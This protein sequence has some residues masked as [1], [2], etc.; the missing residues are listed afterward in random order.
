M[1]ERLNC[2]NCSTHMPMYFVWPSP[3]KDSA[4]EAVIGRIQ[5]CRSCGWQGDAVTKTRY[6]IHREGNILYVDG[7]GY[8]DKADWLRKIG[9][10]PEEPSK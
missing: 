1:N 10:I 4:V 5:I 3:Q 2:P 9:L 7:V 6:E 8:T